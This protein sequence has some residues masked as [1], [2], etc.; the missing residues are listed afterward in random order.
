MVE[1]EVEEKVRL[2][3][4]EADDATSEALVDEEGLL[5]SD[6]V[7]SDDGVLKDVVSA[8]DSEIENK[9]HTSVSTGSRLTGPPRLAEPSAC[10]TAE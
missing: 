3:L 5:A 8:N 7:D 6:G 4:L 2:L 9:K 1:Q 10:S